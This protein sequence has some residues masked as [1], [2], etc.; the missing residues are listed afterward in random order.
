MTLVNVCVLTT[1]VVYRAPTSVPLL[2]LT[3]SL[4]QNNIEIW[5]ND[6]CA[7]SSKCS[8]ERKNCISLT[9]NQK[10]KMV[11]L[12]EESMSKDRLK[13]RPPPLVSQIVNA[14]EEFLKKMKNTTPVSM[15]I[16]SQ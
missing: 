14:E 8:S 13:T 5:L 3:Y 9:L 12:T 4:R 7:M 15:Q 11:M 16:L 10:L 1:P 6:R 2:G